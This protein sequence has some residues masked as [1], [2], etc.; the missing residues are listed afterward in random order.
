MVQIIRSQM[1]FCLVSPAQ[2]KKN[3][4]VSAKIAG[5][6]RVLATAVDDWSENLFAL[7]PDELTLVYNSTIIS[8]SDSSITY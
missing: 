7:A 4:K 3:P 1:S 5:S 8:D 6:C 2:S